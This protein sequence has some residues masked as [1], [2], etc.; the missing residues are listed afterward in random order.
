[1]RSNISY[2]SS[3]VPMYLHIPIHIVQSDLLD[4]GMNLCTQ[5]DHKVE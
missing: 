2:V 5:K 3:N 4:Y 1:M